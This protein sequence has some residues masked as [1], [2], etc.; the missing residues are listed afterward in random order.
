MSDIRKA[1]MYLAYL[2]KCECIIAKVKFPAMLPRYFIGHSFCSSST[3][4]ADRSSCL[5]EYPVA[6]NGN[7]LKQ[8]LWPKESVIKPGDKITVSIWDHE[9]LSVGSVNS[10]FN[11]RVKWVVFDKGG[12]EGKNIKER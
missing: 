7:I 11:S 12:G 1:L 3:R 9:E 6:N 2:W 8:Y 10:T 4:A 5:S